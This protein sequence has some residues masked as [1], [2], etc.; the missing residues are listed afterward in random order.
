MAKLHELIAVE[1]DL[2]ATAQ[3]VLADI[4]QLFTQGQVR[5]IGQVRTYAPVDESGE[6]L[7]GE[8]TELATTVG[9]ELKG[10]RA[11]FVR[12]VDV[13]V[14]KEITNGAT[15]ADVVVDGKTV[16]SSL[17]A[18]ALLNLEQRIAALRQAYAAIPTNDPTET[19]KID[20]QSGVYVSP[21]R[22]TYRTNKVPK[23]IIGAPATKE[24]PAQVQYYNDDVRVGTWT[25]TK[26]SGMLSPIEKRDL[27]ERVDTLA[28]AI[29]EARQRANDTDVAG[30]RVADK[31]FDFIHRE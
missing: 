12:Y 8:S 4:L 11:A 17:S 22:D 30:V 19:W 21:P 5:L 10:L 16:L 20:P 27:L 26:R 6:R 7:F 25:T 9:D 28:R 3:R 29:K 24:H 18:P 1:G 15:K 13:S 14:D 2:K 23:A 31:L